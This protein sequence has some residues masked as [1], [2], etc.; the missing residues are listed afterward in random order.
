MN[1][2][3]TFMR[4]PDLV[5]RIRGVIGWLAVAL[6]FPFHGLAQTLD[7]YYAASYNIRGI[8]VVPDLPGE[9]GGLTFKAGDANTLLIGGAA[10]TDSAKIYSITVV[11]GANGHITGLSG[12]APELAHALRPAPPRR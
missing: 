8:G 6:A 2:K 12:S 5:W 9:Y 10:E 4:I 7:P 3:N 1:R 11:R